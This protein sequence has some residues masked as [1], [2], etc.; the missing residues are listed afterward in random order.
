MDYTKCAIVLPVHDCWG[1]LIRAFYNKSSLIQELLDY[2]PNETF[3]SLIA[4]FVKD[5]FSFIVVE[6]QASCSAPLEQFIDEYYD[7]H[8]YRNIYRVFYGHGLHDTLKEVAEDLLIILETNCG[9]L[10][11]KSHVFVDFVDLQGGCLILQYTE[12]PWKSIQTYPP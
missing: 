5:F 10:I 4:F 12:Q 11:K 3:D 2:Y 7:Q 6:S 8:E 1:Y 9:S